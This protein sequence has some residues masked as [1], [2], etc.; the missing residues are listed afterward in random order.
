[1]YNMP[2]YRPPS[3]ANSLI[4]QATLGCSHN[5]CSFCS[6]YKGKKFT[7]KPLEKIKEEILEFRRID[8]YVQRIFIADGDALIIPMNDLREL[9]KFIKNTFK[10]CT[11]VTMYA[12]PKSIRLKTIDELIEL[13]NLGLEMVYMGI[14]SGNEDILKDI[15]KG[16]TRD[17][18]IQAGK[19]IKESGI[20]LSA[21]IISGIGGKEKTDIHAKDTG[22]I[23]S[24]IKPDYIGVLSLMV[25][26]NTEIEGK[27]KNGE[28][29]ILSSF[30]ILKEIK[31]I[32][33]NINTDEKIIFRSNHASNY[34]S[35]KGTLPIDKGRLIEDIN[36]CIENSYIKNEKNRSL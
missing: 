25:E 22:S 21:T 3:E 18:I 34:V 6:M 36:W 30:E 7:I 1:M 13:K 14:E 20:K 4:I 32:L 31:E 26:R 10:E 24:I 2:L 28:L 27:V 19:K 5:K 11:R 17:E 35:L 15:N 23:I 8:S 29:E 9:L 12:S 33:K 16:A